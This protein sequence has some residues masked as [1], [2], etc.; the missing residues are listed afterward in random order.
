ME[1]F[2]KKFFFQKKV[3]LEKNFFKVFFKK[4]AQCRKTQKEAIQAH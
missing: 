3:F 2:G 4:V 1:T